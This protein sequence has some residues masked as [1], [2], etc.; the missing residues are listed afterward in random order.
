MH[1]KRE[2]DNPEPPGMNMK[3]SDKILIHVC[4]APDATVGVPR[5][6][7]KSGLKP[8]VFFSNSNI[9]PEEEYLLRL[10]ETE[11]L[12]QKMHWDLIA[13]RYEPEEWFSLVTGYETEPEKGFRCELCF[14]ARMERTAET[15][16]KENYGAFSIVWTISPHKDAALINAIGRSASA[17]FGNIPFIADNLKKKE[18]FKES[19][20]LSRE[21][22]LY[23]Q[24]YCGCIFSK[25]T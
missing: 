19:L 18:G 14:R 6:A 25:R 7:R 10:A 16:S 8:V 9:H 24:N 23:R 17:K 22:N 1:C 20:T 4:C 3:N 21:F 12:S 13:D 15:A 11:K 5:L 2:N